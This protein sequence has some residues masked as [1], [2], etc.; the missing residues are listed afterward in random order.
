M[1]TCPKCSTSYNDEKMFCL[2]DGTPLVFVSNVANHQ[3]PPSASEPP[4]TMWSGSPALQQN[5]QSQ[6][7]PFN[8]PQFGQT[9]PFS[10][11]TNSTRPK[12]TGRIIIFGSLIVVALLGVIGVIAGA[13]L[14][15][16]YK[17]NSS[18]YASA[19]N[20]NSGSSTYNSNTR[21]G[22]SSTYN[23]GSSGSYSNNN[24]SNGSSSSSVPE[25]V[26]FGSRNGFTTDGAY[27][28]TFDYYPGAAKTKAAIY[29]KGFGDAVK[30]IHGEAATYASSEDASDG[31]KN[32]LKKLTG[33]GATI[34]ETDTVKNSTYAY[35]HINHAYGFCVVAGISVVDY[36]AWTMEDLLNFLK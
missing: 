15:T 4:P 10:P 36:S 34:T 17:S 18:N 1:K 8:Q 28:K 24:S 33:E 19:S 3:S 2:E 20:Y 6:T 13:V 12:S 16:V 7:P 21:G 27:N 14:L 31:F 25:P 35:Y 22:N 11:N 9:P 30:V 23:S 26:L 29:S 32:H 5:Y